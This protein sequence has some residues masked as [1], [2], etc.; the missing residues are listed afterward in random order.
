M[1]VL[2]VD[3][4]RGIR[5]S[6]QEFFAD[7]GYAVDVAADGVEALRLLDAPDEPLPSV[8]ILDLLM[9]TISGNEVYEHMQSNPRL[10]AVPVIISTSDPARA[11]RGTLTMKKPINL[12]L[13][14][15]N[16][17]GLCQ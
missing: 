10:A 2:V 3:D 12:D 16:V 4:E 8:V 9:P 17:R 1:K 5:E 7:E 15:S 14:L 6:L 13:L 11:P